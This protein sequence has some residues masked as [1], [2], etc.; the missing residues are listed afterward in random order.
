MQE[1][2]TM[3]PQLPVRKGEIAPTEVRAGAPSRPPMFAASTGEELSLADIW[4]IVL[5]RRIT[6]LICLI[7]ALAV[8]G[9]Y[10]FVQR[11]RYESTARI[12]VSFENENLFGSEN[13]LGLLG[14]MDPQTKLETQVRI[15]QSDTLALEV[16]RQLNLDQNP[17]FFRTHD[18]QPVNLSDPG[19]RAAFVGNFRKGLNVRTVPKSELIEITYRSYDPKLSAD[20][21]NQLVEAYTER[22]FQ[23]KFQST[24]QASNWLSKQLDGLKQT[25]ERTQERLAQ[26]QKDNGILFLG[27]DEAHNTTT[28]KL[29]ELEKQLVTVQSERIV[30]EANYHLASNGNPELIAS[31][32]P[33][34]VLQVLRSQEAD[35][36]NQFAQM[37]AKYGANYPK[38]QQ[39]KAQLEQ[40]DNA[41][42]QELKNLAV[43]YQNEYKAAQQT[44]RMLMA[45]LEA[46]KKIAFQQNERAVEYVILKREFESSRQLYDDLLK[47]LKEAG[48]SAGLRSTH[49]T[50]VDSAAIPITP[51]EP[52]LPRN[53]FLGLCAGLGLGIL[54]TFLMENLDNSLRTVEEVEMYTGLPSLGIVP[55]F[56]LQS[57]NRKGSKLRSSKTTPELPERGKSEL[58][59]L[60]RPKS[61]ASECFRA[62]RSSVLLSSVDLPP[63]VIA[64]TSALPQEGKS[65]TSTNSAI[66][67]AQSGARVLLVDADMRRPGLHV[68]FDLDNSMG[69]SG[70]IAGTQSEAEAIRQC[71]QI[72]NL[73][74][75]PAGMSAPYPAELLASQRM[76]QLIEKWRKEYDYIVIDTPPVLSVTDGVIIGSQV[77]TVLLV[78]RWG[79]T[80]WQPL[81][82]SRDMLMRAN[83]RIAGVVV[84]AVN[85]DSPDYY[86]GAGYYYY[87][88][89][90][91]YNYNYNHYNDEDAVAN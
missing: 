33:T 10:S 28:A 36:K 90:Y 16:I 70:V 54:G 91:Y 1:R 72:E 51:V 62:L 45:E 17:Q 84:N 64:V 57:K 14:G 42:Q 21:V 3:N 38:V 87:K 22:N 19:T 63:R 34:P 43:R 12:A 82:R 79:R 80:G 39:L 59:T 68:K 49:V 47:K 11:P 66:V 88:Y 65:T 7:V 77:D 5:K 53:L 44:E 35:L 89:G 40:V 58:I 56:K 71:P 13:G 32:L 29:T 41:L 9:L 37:T 55:N 75:L 85:L 83:A 15:L 46:Q 81:R 27:N 8:A 52:N 74:L 48:I 4:R 69:L 26:Y 86:Y 60:A 23:V 61:Q 25:V 2:G 67:L 30:K 73:Y 78:M 31:P 20:I 18:K 76:A 50:V 24:M 6:I